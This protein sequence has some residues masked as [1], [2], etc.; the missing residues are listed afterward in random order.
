MSPV[1]SILSGWVDMKKC[2]VV[3][4]K[5]RDVAMEQIGRDR[6]TTRTGFVYCGRDIYLGYTGFEST[7]RLQ[8]KRQPWISSRWPHTFHERICWGEQWHV[9]LKRWWNA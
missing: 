7:C 3:V 1:A 8:A 9:K 4:F 6:Y 5:N 2:K